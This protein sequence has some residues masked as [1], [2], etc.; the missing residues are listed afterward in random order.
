MLLEP[1][2]FYSYSRATGTKPPENDRERAAIATDVIDFKRSQLKAPSQSD[3][4]RDLGLVALG[5]GILGSIIGGR[6]ISQRFGGTQAP[7]KKVSFDPGPETKKAAKRATQRNNQKLQKD[8]NEV[9]PS[10]IVES[11]TVVEKQQIDNTSTSTEQVKNRAVTE[12][13]NRD[14]QSIREGKTNQLKAEAISK[15]LNNSD[16]ANFSQDAVKIKETVAAQEAAAQRARAVNKANI[17]KLENYIF[18]TGPYSEGR[19]QSIAKRYEEQP[20]MTAFALTG[21]A[22]QLGLSRKRLR[23]LGLK[24]TDELFGNLSQREADRRLLSAV[25]D[26]VSPEQ[27]KKLMNPNYSPKELMEEGLLDLSPEPINPDLELTAGGSQALNLNR[28]R[29]ARPQATSLDAIDDAYDAELAKIG[30][31]QNMAGKVGIYA[32]KNPQRGEVYEQFAKSWDALSRAGFVL[33]REETID[34]KTYKYADLKYMRVNNFNADPAARL[35]DVENYR[36]SGIRLNKLA[37]EFGLD[38][39]PETEIVVTNPQTLQ[40]VQTVRERSRKSGKSILTDE[41]QYDNLGKTGEGQERLQRQVRKENFTGD[42][43]ALRPRG[44]VLYDASGE[45]QFVKTN[46]SYPGSTADLTGGYKTGEPIKYYRFGGEPIQQKVEVEG[47]SIGTYLIPNVVSKGATTQLR[48]GSPIGRITNPTLSQLPQQTYDPST[49]VLNIQPYSVT[50]RKKVKT[51]LSQKT[52]KPKGEDFIVDDFIYGELVERKQVKDVK[53]VKVEKLIPTSVPLNKMQDL[54]YR[55]RAGLEDIDLSDPEKRKTYYS[56]IADKMYV[57]AKDP[58]LG[59][60][61]DL[62]VLQDFRTQGQFIKNLLTVEGESEA[63]GRRAEGG[64]ITKG[65]DRD[66]YIYNKS[67]PDKVKIPGYRIPKGLGGVTDQEIEAGQIRVD[68]GGGQ[69][70]AGAQKL[71]QALQDFK[72]RTGQPVSRSQLFKLAQPLA[73]QY[74]TDINSLINLAGSRRGGGLR[75]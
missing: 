35:I 1:A 57:M 61:K 16:F 6:K 47:K 11:P 18:E 73:R 2:D 24:P 36:Q 40:E 55:A 67:K 41:V 50:A 15:A 27:A 62:P 25:D 39:I 33:P 19:L 60:G 30:M 51:S 43:R 66:R 3:E 17:Q 44:G 72:A 42:S 49:N 37:R 71:R 56:K 45:R 21:R 52:G 5:A 20:D 31:E 34:G 53:G 48:T 29:R 63:F 70:A 7:P 58:K 69:R 26:A 74:N 14:V 65:T 75:G 38:K 8:L 22:D 54:A 10:K 59:I 46:V 68:I 32:T 64:L 12:Q 13:V 28:Q 9:E 23:E 4:G